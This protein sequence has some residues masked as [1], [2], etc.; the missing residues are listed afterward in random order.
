MIIW[1]VAFQFAI[2]LVMEHNLGAMD[3]IKL[4]ARAGLSN[5]GGI[6]VLYILCGLVG[7]LGLLAL[8]LGYFVAVP[9]MYAAFAFAYRQV[10]PALF[11]KKFDT[12][13]PPPGAY[14]TGFGSGV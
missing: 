6:I 9:V 7:L 1:T 5:V 10:F 13:P 11:E 12:S 8:C 3:A 4:S 2:P 14:G